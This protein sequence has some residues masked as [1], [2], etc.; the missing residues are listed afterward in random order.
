MRA[1]ISRTR[2]AITEVA[3]DW[4]VR[5]RDDEFTSMEQKEFADW[6]RESP[7]HVEEYLA[8]ARMWGV[9]PEIPGIDDL[10]VELPE[11]APVVQLSGHK[12]VVASV[13]ATPPRAIQATK[14]RY[15]IAIAA[16]FLVAVVAAAYL[17]RVQAFLGDQHATGLGE[18]RSLALAD[19][20]VVELNTQSRITVDYSESLRQVH[21]ESGEAFFDVRKGDLR[22]F[23]VVTESASIRVLGTQFN[24]YRRTSDTTVTVVEGKVSIEADHGLASARESGFVNAVSGAPSQ[25]TIQLEAGEQAVIDYAEQSIRTAELPNTERFTAWTERR[26]VF[27]QTG[28][29]QVLEEFARYNDLEFRLTNDEIAALELTGTFESHDFASFVDY[30]EFRTDVS[31]RRDGQ[32]LVIGSAQ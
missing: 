9:V 21:L 24:V 13:T 14:S 4:F 32:V 28:L 5:C 31:V 15:G 11:D 1:E 20:T 12:A 27:E 10:S 22:A 18:Q 30:L 2:A 8:I 19:G 16:S 3:A 7:V 26:L 25:A 17:I 23:E 29:A 6:L